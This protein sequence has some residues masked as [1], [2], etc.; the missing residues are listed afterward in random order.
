MRLLKILPNQDFLLT[1]KLHDD[2]IPQYAILSHTWGDENQE[3]TFEDMIGGSGRD[4]VGY[5]K[6]KFCGDQVARDGLQYFWVDSCCIKKSSDSEL[7]ESLNSMFRWYRRAA[8][9]YVYLSDVSIK[10]E[11]RK[12]KNIETAWEQA[13]RHSRWFTRGWTLQELLAPRFV[14]FFTR[15][16]HRLGDKQSLEQPIQ[17][18]TRIP[19]SA[20]RGSE[21][22]RFSVE[23][24]LDWAKNRQTT[25]GEDWAYSLLGIFGIFMPVLY[26]EGRES[27]INRLRKEI[28]GASLE[29]ESKEKRSEAK[30]C[31]QDLYVTDACADKIRIE[32][33]KGGLLLDSYRWILENGDF[34]QW[35]EDQQRHLLWIKGDPGKG[36]TMLLCGVIDELKKSMAETHLLSYFFCQATDSRINNATAVLRGLLYMLLQQQPMLISHI[37]KLH[38]YAGKKLFE[39]VN[40]W[41]AVSEI[42]TNILQDPI[43]QNTYF[44]IDGLDECTEGLLRLLDF[45]TQKSSLSPCVKW[46]VSSRN[47]PD[48]EGRLDQAKN[49]VRLCLELNTESISTAVNIYI[50]HK[51]GQLSR[52]KKYDEKTQ[53]AILNHLLSNANDTFL[54]VALVCQNLK[55]IPRGRIRARLNEFP[56]GLDSLYKRMMK[57]ICESKD[58]ELYKQ[59]LASIATLYEPV[60]LAELTSLV[61]ALKESSDDVESLKEIVGLCG[62]FLVVQIDTVYFVHQSAKDYLLAEESDK[63]FPSGMVETHYRIGLRSLEVLYRTLRRDIYDLG[64]FGFLVER[65]QR[66]APDPLLA[67]R[68]LCIYWVD[69]LCEWEPNSHV[70]RRVDLQDGGTVEAF[71]REKF[72]YWLEALSHCK[73]MSKGVLAMTKLDSVI[74]VNTKWRD[75]Y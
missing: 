72:L 44:I 7:S 26:G 56:P 11:E 15:D 53:H 64:Q 68:Y 21:L 63:I 19:I 13:F 59:I 67:L 17:E 43:L 58:S 12:G 54:W 22:S 8:K 9:C 38:D 36:K 2:A 62:S 65:A 49:K 70:N 28:Q 16:G 6:I 25:R 33:T 20:L 5:D 75:H 1:P 37:Q 57:Q 39:D 69:H 14:E 4:K 30:Q 52:E 31:L 61:E 40:A 3:V 51:I 55:D 10:E 24:I 71:M 27:A 34:K 29:K 18:I 48:I 73:S 45:I 42:F 23:Q 66:L 47:W 74:Q 35:R 50:K 32:E 46:L 41:V 60:T